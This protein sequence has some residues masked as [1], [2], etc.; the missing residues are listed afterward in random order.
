MNPLPYIIS[1][2]AIADIDEIW[3]Y[4]VNKCSVEQAI[5]YYNSIINEIIRICA[6]PYSG[7][8]MDKIRHGYRFTKVKIPPNI[9]PDCN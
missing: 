8:L 4:T 7:K 3:L 5:R 9:L 1:A 2:E 6:Y